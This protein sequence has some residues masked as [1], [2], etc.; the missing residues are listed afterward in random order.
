MD[1]A[2]DGSSETILVVDDEAGIRSSVRGVLADEGY[3]ASWRRVEEKGRRSATK[4]LRRK[5]ELE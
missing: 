2:T 1:M 3:I 4:R 5:P